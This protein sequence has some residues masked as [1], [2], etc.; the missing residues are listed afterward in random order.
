MNVKPT[1]FLAGLWVLLIILIG[2]IGPMIAPFNPQQPIDDPLSPPSSS[3]ILGTD[4]LGRDQFSRLLY[5]ARNSLSLSISAAV[6]TIIV[7]S[8]MGLLAATFPGIPDQSL[9]WLINAALAIPGLLLA[10]LFVAGLGPGVNTVI[11]AVGIGGIPGFARISRTIFKQTLSQGFVQ[12]VRAL[13]GTWVWNSWY[14][15][16]PNA[17][18]RLIPLATLHIAW[19]FLGTTT[20]TFL[21][22]A[23]DPAIPEWGAMLNA[24]RLHLVQVPLLAII[25]GM[26]MS[27]TI[28]SI[29]T[30]GTWITRQS[31]PFNR[32]WQE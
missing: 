9:L 15:I 11:L 25:P 13:G 2:L 1:T 26:M 31:S 12:S 16:L 22:F 3:T 4:P 28:L 17:S 10:M 24:G 19:A 5:G 14:H 29:H 32:G 23:G 6:L 8:V 27:L 20:L 18:F 7:G 30:I 21:G